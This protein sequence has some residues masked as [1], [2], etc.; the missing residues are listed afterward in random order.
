MNLFY[1]EK[2]DLLLQTLNNAQRSNNNKESMAYHLLRE[3]N[4]ILG[5]LIG[6]KRFAMKT[7]EKS[8][9]KI[10]EFTQ[11]KNIKFLLLGPVSRPFSKFEDR[12]SQEINVKFEK[13]TKEKSINYLSLIKKFNDDN[14]SLFFDNGIHVN[15]SGHDEI[16]R[17]IHIKL[18]I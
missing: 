2:F 6:N 17:M 3:T 10:H 8:V 13:I 18:D 12:L 5:S 1:P 9:L 15:Q 4:Y 16:A 14:K 11:K 7:L